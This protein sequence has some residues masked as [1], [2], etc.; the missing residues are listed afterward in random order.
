MRNP[1]SVSYF[2]AYAIDGRPR[3]CVTCGS[4]R[5]LTIIIFLPVSTEQP[6]AWRS[7]LPH[8]ARSRAVGNSGAGIR[9]A[10]HIEF[11]CTQ[12]H[13]GGY[14][15]GGGPA[16]LCFYGVRAAAAAAAVGHCKTPA[17]QTFRV[18]RT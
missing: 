3:A 17:S 6:E 10:M 16:S 8:S 4:L 18:P 11:P 2:T 7:R 14:V 5:G 9:N 1:H 12:S 13:R 15:V